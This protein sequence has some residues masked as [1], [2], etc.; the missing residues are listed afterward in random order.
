MPSKHHEWCG[1]CCHVTIEH[2]PR[3]FPLPGD[4][5][6]ELTRKILKPHKLHRA[7]SEAIAERDRRWKEKLDDER[8][9]QYY[10]ALDRINKEDV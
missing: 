6:E 8:D 1:E 3:E 9:D 4:I 5:A 10:A 7:I 2:T